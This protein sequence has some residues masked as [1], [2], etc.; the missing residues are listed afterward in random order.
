MNCCLLI[1]AQCIQLSA[2]CPAI[3]WMRGSQHII[4]Q[5][6]RD[7]RISESMG[8]LW[9]T[10]GRAALWLPVGVAV[11]SLLVSVASVRGRS[12]QP[13]L[14]AGLSQNAVRDRVLLDK[15]SVRWRHKY[16]RG[17]VVTLASPQAPGETLIKRLVGVEGDVVLDR[18]GRVHVIPPGRCW[19]EG[20]SPTFSDD[21]EKFG[22]VPLAL[23]EARVVAVLWPPEHAKLVPRVVPEERVNV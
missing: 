18:G 11:N 13:T 3:G 21:S 1:F 22:P 5:R 4:H 9:Q 14:N 23:I 19:V 7:T 12:M 8:R 2:C 10:L 16:R 15:F 6:G 20:D 17:D